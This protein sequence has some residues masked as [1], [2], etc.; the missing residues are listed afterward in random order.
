MV[1]SLKSSPDPEVS[2][3]ATNL[4]EKLRGVVKRRAK[5]DVSS[6]APQ[7]TAPSQSTTQHPRKQLPDHSLLGPSASYWASS[8]GQ[9]YVL[10][11]AEYLMPIEVVVSRVVEADIG[12]IQHSMWFPY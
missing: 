8:C 5:H 3:L 11:N 1:R 2:R 4:L 10:P 6:A 12:G 7:P 9:I